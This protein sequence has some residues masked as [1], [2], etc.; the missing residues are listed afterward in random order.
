MEYYLSDKNL[1]TD[2]FF[3]DLIKNNKEGW[4]ELSVIQKCNAIKNMKLKDADIVAALEGSK[5]VEVSKDNKSIRRANNQALPAAPE[6]KDKN[7]NQKKRDAKAQGKEEAKEEK[8]TSVKKADSKTEEDED[9]ELD[10]RGNY[11]LGQ[12]DFEN[13]VIVHFETASTEKDYKVNWKDVENAIKEKFKKLKITYSRADQ[14]MGELAFSS[15][16]LPTKE[17]ETLTKTVLK[18]KD[19]DF[20]FTQLAGE[21]LKAF[22]VKQGG[23]YNFCIQPKVRNSKKKEKLK[24]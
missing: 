15:H 14:Y 12:L 7:G 18:I 1:K 9:A 8:K 19:K 2:N 22:W 5:D 21:E 16:K 3:Y 6:G 23:H 4:V 24:K 11:V 20:K 17:L 10:G 13:P